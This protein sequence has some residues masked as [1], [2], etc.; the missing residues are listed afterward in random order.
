M[1]NENNVPKRKPNRLKNFDYNSVG[2]YFVTICTK[3]RQKILSTIEPP[4]ATI[5]F[6]QQA[7]GDGANELLPHIISTFKRFCNKEIRH[8]I[9]QRS[10]MEHVIRNKSDYERIKKY[11]NEN[12]IK[13]YY[14]EQ[15]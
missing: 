1:N 6:T 9:F 13:R 10:Y 11:I 3:D 7:V 14:N 5:G 15:K 2:A 12:P 4:T 8:N